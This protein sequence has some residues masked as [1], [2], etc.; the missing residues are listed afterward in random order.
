[1]LEALRELLIYRLQKKTRI[2]FNCLLLASTANSADL[3][4]PPDQACKWKI[5]GDIVSG[6]AN[7]LRASISSLSKSDYCNGG[8]SG[9][10]VV[11]Q[12]T[13]DGGDIDEAM[14]IGRVLRQAQAAT[15]AVNCY[16]SCVIAHL[17]GVQRGSGLDDKAVGIHRPYWT[18]VL[19]PEKIE[20]LRASRSRHQNIL[21]K[22]VQDMGTSV[23]LIDIMESVPPD[24]IYYLSITERD[25][26]RVDGDDPVWEEAQVAKDARYYGVTSMEYRKRKLFGESQCKSLKGADSFNCR[27][28]VFWGIAIESFARISNAVEERCGHSRPSQSMTPQH[29]SWLK[30]V[31]AVTERLR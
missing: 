30:C 20:G 7:R 6:D 22:Y 9:L 23:R 28:A 21:R 8:S 26:L 12:L 10:N 25:A 5:A 31:R 29:S 17:G 3:V 13:S 19:N 15:Y 11:V 18:H 24:K 16:S 27:Q 4:T 2:L 14:E 1:M